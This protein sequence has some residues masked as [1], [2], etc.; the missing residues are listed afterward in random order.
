[1]VL[2]DCPVSVSGWKTSF[3]LASMNLSQITLIS[4]ES[5]W[6]FR[7]DIGI[8]PARPSVIIGISPATN[9]THAPEHQKGFVDWRTVQIA[10]FL[11]S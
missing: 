5:M 8:A 10:S 9:G 2:N 6:R 3:A 7:F 1:M 4:L 11:R